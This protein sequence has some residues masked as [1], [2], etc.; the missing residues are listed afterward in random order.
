MASIG[1]NESA[2]VRNAT[3]LTLFTIF[4]ICREFSLQDQLRQATDSVKNM[5]KLHEFA[6][7]QLLELRTQSGFFSLSRA[8][9]SPAIL[10]L[11]MD[12]FSG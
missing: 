6:Q 7:S 12:M 5:Q 9:P 2:L 4:Y 8:R 10:F 11:S 3:L 1:R